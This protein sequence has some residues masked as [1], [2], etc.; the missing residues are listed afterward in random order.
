MIVLQ[1]GGCVEPIAA[2]G[3]LATPV[4]CFP[5]RRPFFGSSDRKAPSRLIQTLALLA[6]SSSAEKLGIAAGAVPTALTKASEASRPAKNGLL[7][8]GGETLDKKGLLCSPR[9]ARELAFSML[10][11]GLVSGQKPMWVFRQRLKQ[12]AGDFHKDLLESYKYVPDDGDSTFIEDAES[13]KKLEQYQNGESMLEA[14]VLSAPLTLVYNKFALKLAQEIIQVTVDSWTE[15]ELILTD[16]LPETWKDPGGEAAVQQCLLHMAMAEMT[17]RGTSPKI[18]INEAVELGKR[19]YD[20]HAARVIN[21]CLGKF[22]R[23]TYF[24]ETRKHGSIL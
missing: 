4:K 12:T 9:A 2:K 5:H 16:L 3:F 20:K 21:G 22:T 11:A 13:A 15:Q 10:Y 8:W 14:A 1:D 17:K 19:F 18:A 6:S 24:K 7:A 23:S